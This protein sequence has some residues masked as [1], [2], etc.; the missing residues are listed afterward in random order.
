MSARS[1]ISLERIDSV[2]AFNRFY[3]QRIGILGAGLLHSKYTLTEVRVLY[4]IG[5]RESPSATDLAREL[6]LDPGYLSR[7]LA[8]FDKRGWLKRVRCKGD[9][10]KSFLRLTERGRK[11]RSDFEQRSRS[12]IAAL[13]EPLE[14]EQQMQLQGHLESAQAL[15]RAT[16]RRNEGTSPTITV[17]GHRPGDIGWIIQMHGTLYE[18][19]FGWGPAFEA[20]VADIGA[21]FLRN[22]DPQRERCWIAE[23]DGMR[24]GSVMLVRHTD[25]IGKLRLLL[26][27]PSQRGMG[28]G[29]QLVTEC[30]RFARDVGYRRITLWTQ[31]VLRAA[32]R[33]YEQQGFRL[34]KSEPH[35]VFGVKLVGETWELK[36]D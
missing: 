5:A 23:R 26:V 34:V 8:K 19:E 29:K 4:E 3:T 17:R 10:R 11:I 22:F 28:I 35:E 21:S 2:R 20:L 27:D 32:R 36:L 12:E 31:S 24:V 25:T 33:I 6:G 1:Q 7:I 16:Q 18:R 15:I 30:V 13:L 14:P 9:A